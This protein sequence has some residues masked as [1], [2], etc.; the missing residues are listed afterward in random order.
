MIQDLLT[1]VWKESKGLMRVRGSRW[2]AVLTALVPVASIAILMPIQIGADWLSTAFS[3]FGS[4]ILPLLLIGMTIPESFAGERERHTLDTLLASRL[5]DRAILFGKAGLAVGYGWL[6]SMVVVLLAV[7]PVN[8][9]HWSGRVAFYRPIIFVA[10]V[11][12]SLLVSGAMASLGILISL[13][14]ATAQGAQQ[15]LGSAV[16]IPLLVVQIVPAVL[17]SVVPGGREILARLLSIDLATVV[18]IV[19][20]VLVVLNVGLLLAAMARFQRSR[21]VLS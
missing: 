6:M 13:R 17:L 5:P 18:A 19:V 1:V 16:L 12:I 2:R 15:T 11:L 10:N 8:L 21:L 4:L 20:G 9:L 3:L 14:A 7:I